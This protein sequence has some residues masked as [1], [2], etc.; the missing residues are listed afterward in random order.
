M[1]S[2]LH[3]PIRVGAVFEKGEVKPA[4][5]EHKGGKI[6]ILKTFYKWHE[7]TKTNNGVV[8]K[9]SVYDGSSIYEICF[10]PAELKWVLTACEEYCGDSVSF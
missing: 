3:E 7:K 6:K 5:F 10:E 4:W 1:V 8:F 2:S 9:F